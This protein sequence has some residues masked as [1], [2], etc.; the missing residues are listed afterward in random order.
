M[1]DHIEY[2][3]AYDAAVRRNILANA[4]KTFLKTVERAEE[5]VEALHGGREEVYHGRHVTMKYTDNFIGSMAY[6]YDNYGKLTPKQCDA[7]LKGIDARTAR[8]AQWRAEQ[9]A[10]DAQ[11]QHVG[12]VGEKVILN[13]TFERRMEYVNE[14]GCMTIVI[15]RDDLGNIIK[16]KGNAECMTSPVS[17]DDWGLKDYGDEYKRGDKFTIKATIKSHDIYKDV[18][19]TSIARPRKA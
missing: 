11:S 4:N 9:S 5:I 6:A 2:P 18:K 16:Y 10:M 17:V 1:Q 14:Y 19:Q 12:E 8:M 15:A 13:L 7:I 3:D